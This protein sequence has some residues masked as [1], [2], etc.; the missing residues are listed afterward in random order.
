MTVEPQADF[1][2][3][4]INERVERKKTFE[5]IL[6]YFTPYKK[7]FVNLFVVMLLVTGLQALLP[8]ISKAVIDVGIQTQDLNFINIGYDA[9]QTKWASKKVKELVVFDF[10]M[11]SSNI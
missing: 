4:E 11:K 2:Q 7:S 9:Q 8:F 1:K 3:R 10:G 6:G 5:N